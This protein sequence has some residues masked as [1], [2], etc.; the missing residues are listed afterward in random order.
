MLALALAAAPATGGPAQSGDCNLRPDWP[1][2]RTDLAA[3]VVVLVNAY[4]ERIGRRALRVSPSLTRAAV[5]KAS[6]MARY[7]YMRHD[8]PAPPVKRSVAERLEACGYPVRAFSAGEN[9]AFGFPTPDAVL[10]G[11]LRSPGHRAN[12][13]RP[14]FTVIGV[15]VAAAANGVLYWTQE[16]G[17]YEG[18]AAAARVPRPN[19]RAARQHAR[20]ARR[21]DQTP[22]S[23]PAVRGP[24][25][26][27]DPAPTY[28]F[29]SRDGRTPRAKIRYRCSFNSSRLHPCRARYRQPLAFRSHVLRVQAV[30]AAGNRSSITRIVVVIRASA[31]IGVTKR[32]SSAAVGAGSE[33]TYTIVARNSGPAAAQTVTVSDPLPADVRLVS[34]RASTGGCSAETTVVCNLAT[35]EKG[36]TAT[37]TLV[38]VPTVAGTLTNRASVSSPTPDRNGSN[39]QAVAVVGVEP[40][41]SATL[42]PRR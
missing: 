17:T 6:H 3:Q 14:N 2:P 30:D 26:T 33:L 25:E 32:A 38:V 40:A 42:A 19:A 1:R 10:G 20:N 34:A 18:G 7:R 29:S 21:P 39:N 31:D 37:V 36:E 9:I 22:P 35:L 15:G 12:I 23:R 5:W 28:R 16:F 27:F 11:W 41:T 13:A 8:D 4:R 24:R